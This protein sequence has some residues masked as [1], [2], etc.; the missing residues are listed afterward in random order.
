[1]NR[2]YNQAQKLGAEI[3]ISKGIR[4][5]CECKPNIIEVENISQITARTIVI[6][7]VAEYRKPQLKNL[8]RFEGQG[9]YYVTTL[10]EAQFCD[11]GEMIA[12]G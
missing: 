12:V 3:F 10:V 1:M 2:A 11:G 4:L 9:V 6:A 7:M 8:S 5:I